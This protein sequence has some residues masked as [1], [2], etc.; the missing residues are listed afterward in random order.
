M[1]QILL[2][3]GDLLADRR[4]NYAEML[5]ESG[6]ADAAADLMRDALALAP[7]W[8]TGWFRLGEMLEEAGRA[9]EA[10]AAW[11]GALRLDPSDRL[12]A[13]MKLSLAGAAG[14]I[15]A[16]PAAF[17]EALFDQYAENFDAVLVER[18]EYRVP[19]LLFAALREAGCDAFAHVIDL[20]CGTGLMGDRLRGIA[21]YM[22]GFDI[23]AGMLR[24]AEMKRVYDRLERRD[25]Q[26]LPPAPSIA[27]L[28]TASDVLM[29]IGEL[30]AL[31]SSV[32]GL[33]LPG[34]L[35]AFSVE[36]LEGPEDLVLRPSRR[37]AH[38]AAYVT[39]ALAQ[40][41]FDIV[42]SSITD[43]RKDRGEPIKGLL[44]IARRGVDPHARLQVPVP[45][46]LE[47]EPVLMQ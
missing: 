46:E 13:A 2:S 18:L 12:G 5:L 32:A 27:D 24:Q 15:I 35:F 8:A 43:I 44:V 34:G 10:E 20:G 45:P 19:D 22:E 21:S 1:K 23:S 39:K 29:Y 47:T 42:A 7:A 33:V 28:V 26:T 9:A 41:G 6:D 40:A 36:L 14:G 30:E 3:S 11:R 16:P 4:A 25:L 31:F 37:Y 17:V 38:S